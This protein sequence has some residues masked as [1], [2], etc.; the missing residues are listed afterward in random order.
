[1]PGD[2]VKLLSKTKTQTLATGIYLQSTDDIFSEIVLKTV[3]ENEIDSSHEDEL[4]LPAPAGTATKLSQSL[5]KTVLV[6]KTER[7]QSNKTKKQLQSAAGNKTNKQPAAAGNKTNKQPAAAGNKTNKQPAAA[8]NKTNKQP[9]AAGNKTNKQ[10]AAA[11]NKTNKQPAALATRPTNNL[12]PLAT[13]P[14]NRD[15]LNSKVIR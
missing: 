3:I 6:W 11:G 13:R 1:M 7:L 5:I 10:P 2:S 15:S 12:L 8:G 9:A 4:E 14:T